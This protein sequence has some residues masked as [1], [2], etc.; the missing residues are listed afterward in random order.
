MVVTSLP[1]V[2][3]VDDEHDILEELEEL[4]T[5]RGYA[6]TTAA[7]IADALHAIDA[8]SEIGTLV[9]DLK[10]AGDS[11]LDLVRACKAKDMARGSRM[12]FAV[13]T[14]Q[15]D[16]TTTLCGELE[17]AGITL[18]TKPVPIPGLRRFVSGAADA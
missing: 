4:L 6:V 16:L 17:E 14:A 3:I 8:N 18:M 5:S 12:R 9:T 13:M 7:R 11:G 15:T 1:H 10:L 2:L